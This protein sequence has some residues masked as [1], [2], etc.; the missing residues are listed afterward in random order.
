[1]DQFNVNT[2]LPNP[3]TF[4]FQ[5]SVMSTFGLFLVAVAVSYMILSL[6][7]VHDKSLRNHYTTFVMLL[8]LSAAIFKLGNTQALT[9][10]RY[11]YALLFLAPIVYSVITSFVSFE[12]N[13]SP[14]NL[15][16]LFLTATTV[17]ATLYL[18]YQIMTNATN[19]N[20]HY[21]LGFVT[22]LWFLLGLSFGDYKMNNYVLYSLI[23]L[24]ARDMSTY[25]GVLGG[26]SIGMV[27]HSLASSKSLGLFQEKM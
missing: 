8:F 16:A 2:R 3:N 25:S 15:V 11:F 21:I 9:S 24:H 4:F 13:G 14:G 1:M 20:V 17:S 26:V 27:V 19:K 18:I 10:S 5:S 6:F 23:A 7:F 12:E 22:I